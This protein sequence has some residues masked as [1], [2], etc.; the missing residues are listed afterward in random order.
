M[1]HRR[2]R[3]SRWKTCWP[4]GDLVTSVS[5]S[6]DVVTMYSQLLLADPAGG[7]P[8]K[9]TL[10]YPDDAEP[11]AG[12]V[13]VFSPVGSSLLGLRVGSMARWRTPHGSSGAAE[14]RA[15]LFQPEASG[16]YTT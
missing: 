4:P 5:V 14:I 12:F 13:S 8:Y 9:L 11:A 7:E 2:W 15:I 1:P 6:P 16:D 10:C 3:G